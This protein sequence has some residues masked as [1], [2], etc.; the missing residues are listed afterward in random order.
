MNKL[1]GK[2]TWHIKNGS[3]KNEIWENGSFKSS[4]EIT[5]KNESFYLE[6]IPVKALASNWTDYI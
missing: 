5:D 4:K 3:I 2:R 1:H 6:G